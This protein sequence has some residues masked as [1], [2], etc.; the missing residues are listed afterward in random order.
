[1]WYEIVIPTT[2]VYCVNWTIDIRDRN[3]YRVEALNLENLEKSS[4]ENPIRI[5]NHFRF[6]LQMEKVNSFEDIHFHIVDYAVF[7]GMLILS[8]VSGA[9][10]GFC[11]RHKI[12]K[13]ANNTRSHSITRRE[14][15]VSEATA[16]NNNVNKKVTDF[17]S[18][19]MNEYLL[20]SRKLKSFPV[21]MSLVAR[22]VVYYFINNV[23]NYRNTLYLRLCMF[24][25]YS[26]ISGVTILGKPDYCP[27]SIPIRLCN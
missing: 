1:M 18:T 3:S 8:A 10:F 24:F 4:Y 12:D 17:G 5:C 22:Y 9:Y 14:S 26:Y 25:S 20:G 2:C 6:K 11:R 7:I 21:A 16:K 15:L 23:L 13:N 19:T 27:C